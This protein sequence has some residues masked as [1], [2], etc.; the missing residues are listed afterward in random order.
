VLS[1]TDPNNVTESFAYN[2]NGGVASRTNR[3]GQTI[4]FA[5][6]SLDRLRSR[7]QQTEGQTTTYGYDSYGGQWTSA[8]NGV[9]TDTTRMGWGVVTQQFTARAGFSR[10]VR[11]SYDVG[12]RRTGVNVLMNGLPAD[13]ISYGYGDAGQ[14]TAITDPLGNRTTI[15]YNRDYQP[16]TF[17]LAGGVIATNTYGAT[18]GLS[19]ISF[20]DAAINSAFGRYYRQDSLTRVRESRDRQNKARR[21]SY[22]P[23]GQLTDYADYQIGP[24]PCF[25]DQDYG[26]VC[27]PAPETYLGGRGY[28]YDAVGNPTDAG[29]SIASSNRMTVIGGDSVVY[30][31][32]GNVIRRYRVG[33]PSTFDQT[34]SWNSL[35][36]LVQVSTTRNG[37]TSTLQLAYDGFGRRVQKTVVGVSATQYIWDGDQVVAETDGV[38]NTQRL[39]TYY[40]GTDQLHSVVAG[41][42][43]YYAASDASGNVIGMISRTYNVVSDVYSY[44]PFGVLERNDQGVPNSLRWKGLQY[45]TES[46]LYYMRARYYS[47]DMGRFLSEDPI[48]LAGGIN[49]YTFGG[50]DPVNNSDP[51]G[52]ICSRVTSGG[53]GGAPDQVST[54]CDPW[55]MDVR[56]WFSNF[57]SGSKTAFLMTT[58]F[59][60]GFGPSDRIFREGSVQV[61]QMRH[62]PGVNHAR[63]LAC[64]KAVAGG[65]PRVTNYGARFGVRG[66]LRAGLNP[67]RQFVGS[68]DVEIAPTGKGMRFTLSNTTS[69]RSLLDGVG[70]DWERD[71]AP[72]GIMGNMRQTFTWNESMASCAQ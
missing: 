40:P 48:G 55:W 16:T 35:G 20:N 6:D 11:A 32:D 67:T 62:A 39:Y 33:S 4:T 45:D 70:P 10:A 29:V 5:Y 52:L 68:Y 71:M 58:Q 14:L 37:V 30:D 15:G 47:P 44:Q 54:V 25:F 41:A 38:G 13:S 26:R 59:S 8:S 69:F 22:D 51:S 65:A 19:G 43:T 53:L 56:D 28:G 7:Y 57:A 18:H 24:A 17:T 1:R 27:D 42:Q 61:A 72:N 49:P 50:N 46:G 66:L 31:P 23:A 2:A 21:F 60:G 12:F 9:S 63:A 34:L 64:A 3:R 36:Q